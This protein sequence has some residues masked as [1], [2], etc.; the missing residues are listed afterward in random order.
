MNDEQKPAPG[1]KLCKWAVWIAAAGVVVTLIGI[2][3]AAALGPFRAMLSL[4]LGSLLLIIG[5]VLAAIGL[6]RSRGTGGNASFPLTVGAL[7][8]GAAAIINLLIM[9]GSG[10][11]PPIHDISTDTASPPE[12]VAVVEL[13]GPTD[14]PPEY[15]GDETARLQLE[16]YPD[17]E[18]IV[19]LDPPSFVF[20]T[21]LEVAE[22]MG[23][24]IVAS[25][26]NEGRIE[27][28]ATTPWVGFKDDVVIRIRADGP[29]TRV[30]VRSKSRVGRGDM[31]VNAK[32]IRAFRDR[33]VATA[34]P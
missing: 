21:A 5:A 14:N 1:T 30:D 4:T 33:L 8:V 25:N 2:L 10:G 27:A 15:S 20:E 18:T 26:A 24:E 7:A 17:I 31:G 28:T 11:G 13:R 32:R 23:W 34:E 9:I 3:G 29:E 6:V 19:L 16:A 22:D 12:F